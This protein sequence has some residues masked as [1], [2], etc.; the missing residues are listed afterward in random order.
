MSM[1]KNPVTPSGIKPTTFWFVA[2]CLKQLFHHVPPYISYILIIKS[3]YLHFSH[4]VFPS[5]IAVVP[6]MEAF[7]QSDPANSEHVL[8]T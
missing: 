2:Q 3:H 1:K 4:M 7:K 6:F 8:Y 5:C